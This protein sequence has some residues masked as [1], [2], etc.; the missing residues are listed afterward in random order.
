MGTS[1]SESLGF[2][3]LHTSSGNEDLGLKP[4]AV[5]RTRLSTYHPTREEWMSHNLADGT[6]NGKPDKKTAAT[7]KLDFLTLLA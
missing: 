1:Y 4:T 3:H 2:V 7:H 6:G 5:L